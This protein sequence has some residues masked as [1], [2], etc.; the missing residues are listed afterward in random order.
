MK[1][2]RL[3]RRSRAFTLI[4]LLVVMGI[5]VLMVALVIPAVSGAL[6]GSA[7]NQAAQTL[8]SQFNSAQQIALA[9]GLPIEM[10]LYACGDPDSATADKADSKTFMVQALQLYSVQPNLDPA[11]VKDIKQR[12]TPI[13]KVE[14]L[15]RSIIVDNYITLSSICDA[16]DKK[17]FRDVETNDVASDAY[18]HPKLPRIGSN[19]QYYHIQFRPDGTTDLDPNKS[20]FVTL[21]NTTNGVV[22]DKLPAPPSNFFTLELDAT[23]GST[24]TFRPM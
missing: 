21:H 11:T 6:K 16:T 20:W 15:P 2:L 18:L 17:H 10:R 12:F 4:E 8:Q 3:S 23:Q 7:L 13:T 24:R 9:K 14:F 1:K 19:Y 22:G 5:I